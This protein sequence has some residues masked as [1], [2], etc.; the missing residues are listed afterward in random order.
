MS[1]VKL[2]RLERFLGTPFWWRNWFYLGFFLPL[3]FA[4]GLLLLMFAG[5]TWCG[6]L[7]CSSGELL[8]N[9]FMAGLLGVLWLLGSSVIAGLPFICTPWVDSFRVRLTVFR[10]FVPVWFVSGFLFIQFSGVA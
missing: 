1:D 4:G 10:F 2:T 3:T 6:T 9:N 5:L 7:G 8:G